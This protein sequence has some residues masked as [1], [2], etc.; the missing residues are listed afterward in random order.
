MRPALQPGQGLI[1]VRWARRRS[2]QVRVVRHP[3]ADM[4]I[5]K[6][7]SHRVNISGPGG[8][9]DRW[10]VT[11]DNAAVGVDSRSL[12]AI[13]MRDSWLVVIAVPLRWM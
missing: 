1:A 6:R 9:G 2:G 13:D 4:W 8:D 12:G 7:L 3:H 10:F 11:A 5:V